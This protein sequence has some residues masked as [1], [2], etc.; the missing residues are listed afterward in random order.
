MSDPNLLTVMTPF[1][2]TIDGTAS[3]PDA[4][5]MM[6]EHAVRHLPVTRDGEPIGIVSKQYLRLATAVDDNAHQVKDVARI[7]TYVTDYHTP[8]AVAPRE[9]AVDH[10]G[11]ALITRDGQLVG[12]MTTTDVYV[13][14]ANLLDPPS[15]P[16]RVA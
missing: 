13:A 1:P 9:M 5:H 11:S 14:L 12:I 6:E 4:I 8:L 2:F 10:H 3:I 7:P 16:P 15:G